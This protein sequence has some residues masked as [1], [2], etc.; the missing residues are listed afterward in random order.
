MCYSYALDPDEVALAKELRIGIKK[1]YR[2]PN[3]ELL[4]DDPYYYVSAFDNP[5]MPVIYNDPEHG[6]SWG[7][8]HWGLL[9]DISLDNNFH[10][11]NS[12]DDSVFE[13]PIYNA[14]EYGED[15]DIFNRRCIVPMTGF[16]DYH[17]S[18]KSD[19]F[20]FYFR[21]IQRELF[22]V[23]GI[24]RENVNPDTGSITRGFSLITTD[25]NKKIGLVHNIAQR[26]MN[27]IPSG[28]EEYWLAEGLNEDEIKS[29]IKP[30]PDNDMYCHP[31]SKYFN[32]YKNK[33]NVPEATDEALEHGLMLSTLISQLNEIK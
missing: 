28:Y 23:S 13:K 14:S 5:K 30:Y 21:L 25:P 9:T 11:P 29:L 20:Q 3:F 6:I 8:M 22:F 26:M 19:K 15:L 16:Y 12:R 33:R 24:W 31:I 32:S 18:G 1:P 2:P 4:E 27:I 17:S 10:L 7:R